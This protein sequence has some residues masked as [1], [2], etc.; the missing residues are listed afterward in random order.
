MV[1]YVDFPFY[2]KSVEPNV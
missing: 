2:L 1:K